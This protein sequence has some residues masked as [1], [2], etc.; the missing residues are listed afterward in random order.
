MPTVSVK[1]QKYFSCSDFAYVFILR[2]TVIFC[3]DMRYSVQ[4]EE[5]TGLPRQEPKIKPANGAKTECTLRLLC[6][7]EVHKRMYFFPKWAR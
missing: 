4:S 1:S 5:K 3:V 6:K 7:I 2:I